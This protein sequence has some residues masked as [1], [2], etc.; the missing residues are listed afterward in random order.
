MPEF[1]PRVLIVLTGIV[2]ILALFIGIRDFL[3]K[4]KHVA[5]VMNSGPATAVPPVD[6]RAR[7]KTSSPARTKRAPSSQAVTSAATAT[8]AGIDDLIIRD[9]AL[10]GAPQ[11]SP[12][13]VR[14]Q[15]SRNEGEATRSLPSCTPLPNSTKPK[16]VDAPYYRKWSR[17]YG[18]NAY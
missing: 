7:K 17:E 11:E 4:P 16:D 6:V 18:C 9:F 10:G 14:A 2:A 5:P 12:K 3:E 15:S 1:V 8:P 13:I